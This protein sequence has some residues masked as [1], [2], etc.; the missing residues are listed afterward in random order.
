VYYNAVTA[1]AS[2]YHNVLVYHC[3][4]ATQDVAQRAHAQPYGDGW[5]LDFNGNRG[6]SSSNTCGSGHLMWDSSGYSG[7]Q[8]VMAGHSSQVC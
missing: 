8:N 3:A 7:Q 6:T 1:A 2:A 5:S 4:C